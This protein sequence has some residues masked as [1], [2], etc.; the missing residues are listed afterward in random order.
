ED[1]DRDVAPELVI[2]GLPHRRGRAAVELDLELVA[3]VV[4]RA[5]RRRRA[6]TAAGLARVQPEQRLL[7]EP[8]LVRAPGREQLAPPA[9]RG[10][11][12]LAESL[13]QRDVRHDPAPIP[14][15]IPWS[16]TR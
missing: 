3:L 10:R 11:R 2:V 12:D 9:D 8:R 16:T 1:L 6:A 5:E 4:H 14:C 7:H 15:S 13:A